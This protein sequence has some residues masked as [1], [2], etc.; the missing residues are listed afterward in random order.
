M[1]ISYVLQQHMHLIRVLNVM[2]LILFN[3][4][5]FI[6]DFDRGRIHFKMFPC[7]SNIFLT[8]KIVK[9]NKGKYPWKKIR[10]NFCWYIMYFLTS[11]SHTA[12]FHVVLTFNEHIYELFCE[13]QHLT[14]DK[15]KKHLCWVKFLGN[16]TMLV[17]IYM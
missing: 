2:A 4:I 17:N 15:I 13:V 8:S 9:R 12:M 6:I 10:S 1:C 16:L 3:V 7:A 5:S 11:V 14:F